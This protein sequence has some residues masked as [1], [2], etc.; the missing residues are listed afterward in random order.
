[1]DEEEA[2][3]FLDHILSHMGQKPAEVFTPHQRQQL[4]RQS[5]GVPAQL[6]AELLPLPS[7]TYNKKYL[8][9]FSREEYREGGFGKSFV[10]K[11]C[12]CFV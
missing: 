8:I 7:E 6:L 10:R 11:G 3:F 2:G 4:C 12:T 5:F 9:V 1:M